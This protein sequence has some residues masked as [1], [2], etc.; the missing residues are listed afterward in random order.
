MGL[1]FLRAVVDMREQGDREI[2]DGE[3]QILFGGGSKNFAGESGDL[4][5]AGG[6]G[7]KD[8]D[9]E[10]GPERSDEVVVGLEFAVKGKC[11]FPA[12]LEALREFAA[13][14]ER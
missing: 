14:L 13:P 8:H 10:F 9:V 3:V 4:G 1:V 12:A 2:G 7:S 5:Q 6:L 11:C